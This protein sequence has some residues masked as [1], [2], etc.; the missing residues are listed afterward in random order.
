VEYFVKWKN[1]SAENNSWIKETE[2][3]STDLI[4]EFWQNQN[5]VQKQNMDI[6]QTQQANQKANKNIYG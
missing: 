4:E 3:E 1:F 5:R 2:F 6:D